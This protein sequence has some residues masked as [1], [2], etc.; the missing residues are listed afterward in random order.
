MRHNLL[1]NHQPDPPTGVN[2]DR[3]NTALFYIYRGKVKFH[4][5]VC[6]QHGCMSIYIKKT[7]K[8]REEVGE[9]ERANIQCFD[10]CFYATS[11]MHTCILVYIYFLVLLFL[12]M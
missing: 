5:C 12:E 10:P 4:M 9:L 7:K 1:N 8:N 11:H 2:S 6:I 3:V